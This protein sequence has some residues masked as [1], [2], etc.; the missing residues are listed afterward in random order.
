MVTF[1]IKFKYKPRET[2]VLLSIYTSTMLFVWFQSDQKQCLVLSVSSKYIFEF[3][4]FLSKNNSEIYH[5]SIDKPDSKNNRK[6]V[7]KLAVYF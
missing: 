5:K 6:M 4:Y 7:V 3:I 1:K 2:K